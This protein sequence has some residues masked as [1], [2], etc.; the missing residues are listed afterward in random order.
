MDAGEPTLRASCPGAGTT[1]RNAGTLPPCC[2]PCPCPWLL[3]RAV[4][5]GVVVGG[6]V[7]DDTTELE[8]DNSGLFL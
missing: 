2:C 7:M 4:L 6:G 1:K 5:S 8:R 3:K